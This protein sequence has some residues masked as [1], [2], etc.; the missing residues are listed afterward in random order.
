MSTDPNS[1]TTSVVGAGETYRHHLLKDGT[2]ELYL[3]ASGY[4][5]LI[6][7]RIRNFF[8]PTF[9]GVWIDGIFLALVVVLS[10]ISRL[11]PVCFRGTRYLNVNGSP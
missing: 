3:Y 7:Q 1:I 4:Q 8:C 2:F 9:F 6:Y 5:S 10:C 11:D